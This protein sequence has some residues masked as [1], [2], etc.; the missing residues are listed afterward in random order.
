MKRNMTAIGRLFAG[1]LAILVITLVPLRYKAI[2]VTIAE[3]SRIRACL[4]ETVSDVIRDG[5]ITQSDLER[6]SSYGRYR[7]ELTTG[8]REEP[9]YPYRGVDRA[10]FGEDDDIYGYV[11]TPPGDNELRMAREGEIRLKYGDVF[12]VRLIQKES[13]VTERIANTLVNGII[14]D[15]D[16]TDGGVFLGDC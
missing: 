4:S 12:T 5:R 8:E 9:V 7:V 10:L 15:E 16:M 13:T 2:R 1:V 6:L 3:K 11:L 14:I